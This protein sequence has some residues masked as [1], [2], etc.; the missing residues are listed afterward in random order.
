MTWARPDSGTLRAALLALVLAFSLGAGTGVTY[1]AFS[2]S[3]S[4]PGPT[5]TTKRI[6]P[7]V[8]STAAFSISDRSGGGAPTDSS[9]P[10]GFAGD[11]NATVTGAW[12]TAFSAARYLDFVMSAPLPA[13]IPLSGV[14]FTFALAST[15]AGTSCFYFDVRSP[16]TDV[17]IATRGS[18]GSPVGCATAT[19]ATFT[20]ALAELSSSSLANAVK[21][22]V[23]ESHSGSSTSTTDV[24]TLGGTGYAPFTL[25]PASYTDASTGT[26]TTTPWALEA[27]DAVA[28]RAASNWSST[29]STSRYIDFAF[30]AYVPAAGVV[31]A[32]TFT[33]TYMDVN[34][35]SQCYY[36]DVLVAG[37]VIAT[38]GS[39]AA[40]YCNTT[41]S[42]A[43]DV[44]AL[45][46]INT[47]ARA[48]GIVLR[49]YS[50]NRG[51]ARR[52]N[53][54]VVNLATSYYLD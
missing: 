4:S 24:A 21:I 30:P 48:N 20:T 37:A 7:A 47:S 31:T 50:S 11:G 16:S 15:A 3:A 34:G 6:F 39:A 45:P 49:M 53:D 52:S 12:T 44:I 2:G 5:V 25:Y 54:D 26:A 27:A 18:A 42:Y 32:A 1:A 8:R 36:I 46:E 51:G 33:H 22:R 38:H 13:G 14:T 10:F 19:G 35:V 28:Y 23:Y 43:T 29:F 41:A 9:S 40:P 17:V